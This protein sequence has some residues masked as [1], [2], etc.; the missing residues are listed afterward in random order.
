[1]CVKLN[2]HTPY[3]GWRI[4]AEFRDETDVM[5][6]VFWTGIEGWA[7]EKG[8]MDRVD[9]KSGTPRFLSVSQFLSEIG[10]LGVRNTEDCILN[11]YPLN[12]KT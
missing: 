11:Y 12:R 5:A 4:G 7:A 10:W 8:K 3:C 6:D 1:L 2:F 9:A